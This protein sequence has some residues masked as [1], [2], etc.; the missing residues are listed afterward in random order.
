MTA[1]Q[2]PTTGYWRDGFSVFTG[3][4]SN[5]PSLPKR[6]ARIGFY[7]LVKTRRR[8]KQRRHA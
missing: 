7:S 1:F 8:Q 3:H 4:V 5:G 6:R 2:H